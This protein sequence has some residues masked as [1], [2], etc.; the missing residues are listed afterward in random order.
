MK[1]YTYLILFSFFLVTGLWAQPDEVMQRYGCHFR[2]CDAHCAPLTPEK[3]AAIFASNS[4]SDS[5]DIIHYN[6]KV[7]ITSYTSKKLKGECTVFYSPKMEGLNTITLDLLGL[8]V[9]SL[10][11][12]TGENLAFTHQG[13]SLVVTL[14]AALAVGETGALTVWYQ[15]TPIQ[16]PSGFGGVYYE[17][18]YIYNLSIGLTD[19]PHNFGHAWFPCFDNF[20]ERSSYEMSFLTT[21]PYRTYASGDFVEE[22]PGPDSTKVW[23]KYQ[24]NVPSCTYHISFAAADYGQ[25]VRPHTNLWGDEYPIEILAH[26]SDTTRAKN[27]CFNYL[28]EAL[29]CF[30]H[31][32]GPYPYN[33]VG[34]AMAT[35]G[36]MENPGNTIY[37]DFLIDPNNNDQNLNILTH[38]LAHQW[39][40]NVVTVGSESDMWVKEGNAEYGAHLFVEHFLGETVAI[41]VERQ[42][43][44]DMLYRAHY[45]DGAFLP[46]SPMPHE[47]TYGVT[48]Y[49]KGALTIHNLR[50]YLGDSL[51]RTGMTHL[52]TAL[53]YEAMDAYEMR[54]SLTAYTGVDMT[55]FFADWILNPGWSDFSL[56]SCVVTPLADGNFQ[57]SVHVRQGLRASTHFHHNA[58]VE[59][60]F[61][62]ADG[63]FENRKMVAAGE[64]GSATFILPYEPRFCVLNR[65]QKM[66][67][68]QVTFDKVVKTTGS[69]NGINT[70]FSMNVK[71]VPA[72]D[73]AYVWF[74]HHWSA[75][76]VT[77]GLPS[78]V[79]ISTNHYW[80]INGNWPDGFIGNGIIRYDRGTQNA[81]LDADLLATTPEDSLIVLYRPGAGY[82][83][84]RY[85]RAVVL[86]VGSMTD[87]IGVLRLDTM[88]RGEYALATGFMDF[89]VSTAAP[90]KAV[91]TLDVSPNP[92]SGDVQ[93][94]V[95]NALDADCNVVLYTLW[96]TQVRQESLSALGGNGFAEWQLENLPAG[97]YMLQ[98]Q[99]KFGKPIA[100]EKVVKN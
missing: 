88:V 42:N 5:F 9:D 71:N 55:D 6:I 46:L 52:Q 96:G 53:R 39:W 81:E 70:S 33:K 35:R 63:T 75:P 58:P 85:P 62:K 17:S 14:P 21:L 89:P 94:F 72:G 34:Y 65:T 93:I 91:T 79:K 99:D 78:T 30:E 69:V 44:V 48:T 24:Q 2:K 73:S 13:I 57:A 56:D 51:F 67:L 74:E 50:Y 15:G 66:N 84:I 16:S 23:R 90:E 7:D 87:G 10:K 86:A 100:V 11:S 98:V 92:T 20:V 43:N 25:L 36:A 19:D 54:D 76:E 47:I 37:P 49:N 68:A 4:R 1:K 82:E 28:H 18:N 8:T 32:F 40:G 60:N 95:N 80:N 27:A 22:T 38:E 77:P 59:V 64:K 12:T 3:K 31:W 97:I 45:D 41:G 61:R 29:D 83:W 26:H